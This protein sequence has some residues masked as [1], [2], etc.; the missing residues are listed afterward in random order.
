M[1]GSK[2]YSLQHVNMKSNLVSSYI[3]TMYSKVL[4]Q[5]FVV[6]GVCGAGGEN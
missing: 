5:Q 4:Q 3:V 1:M 6:C 2:G